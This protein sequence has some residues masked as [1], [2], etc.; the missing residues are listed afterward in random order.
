MKL[1]AF[2]DVHGNRTALNHIESVVK[3]ENPDVLVCAGDI[4]VFERNIGAIMKRLAS[5]NKPLLMIHGNH[6]SEKVMKAVCGWFDN[7]FFLHKKVKALGDCVFVGWGGGGFSQVDK[8]FEVFVKSIL[9]KSK[10]KKIVLV[11]HGPP[12]KTAL[13]TLDGRSVGCVSFKKFIMSE[14][15]VVLAVSGHIHETAGREDKI[16]NARVINPGPEGK[17]V[18]V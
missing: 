11:T 15:S 14:T 1:F 10:G 17:V 6:E 5:L 16:N 18:V 13:D 7:I 2:V 9:K 3:R 4:S 12:Y 8:G